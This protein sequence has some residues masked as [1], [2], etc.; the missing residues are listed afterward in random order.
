[1]TQRYSN[2]VDSIMYNIIHECK[3]QFLIATVSYVRH[4]HNRLGNDSL[5]LMDQTKCPL[6]QAS[7]N[8]Q[9]QNRMARMKAILLIFP[10]SDCLLL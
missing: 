3:L 1:M 9:E 5:S 10:H 6:R 8:R 7:Q 2:L 4:S